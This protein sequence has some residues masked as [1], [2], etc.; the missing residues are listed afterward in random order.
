MTLC[1]FQTKSA[2][3]HEWDAGATFCFFG[4]F[5][6]SFQKTEQ[7]A[8]KRLCKR[9][10]QKSSHSPLPRADWLPISALLAPSWYP[11]GSLKHTHTGRWFKGEQPTV[12]P[13]EV[14]KCCF[15][16][17]LHYCRKPRS[18]LNEHYVSDTN[19]TNKPFSGAQFHDLWTQFL[20]SLKLL[21]VSLMLKCFKRRVPP[22][23]PP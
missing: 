3:A 8:N 16:F 1:S 22:S 21:H 18:A 5:F 13:H 15:F 14:R 23:T 17:L 20:V 6:L 4:V 9:R 11:A 7:V 10:K 12:S 19:W 2:R